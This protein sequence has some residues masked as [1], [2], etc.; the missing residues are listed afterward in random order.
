M[1]PV[2]Q[3][4]SLSSATAR[5]F[6]DLA[7]LSEVSEQSLLALLLVGTLVHLAD[8]EC[9]VGAV[10]GADATHV[11]AVLGVLLASEAVP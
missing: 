11:V 9:S 7:P 6:I 3:L 4:F 1:F 8:V 2:C 5:T 10:E